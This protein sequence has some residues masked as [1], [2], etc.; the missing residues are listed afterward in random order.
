MFLCSINYTLFFKLSFF[1]P[2]PLGFGGTYNFSMDLEFGDLMLN[3]FLPFGCSS[4]PITRSYSAFLSFDSK[5]FFGFSYFTG[6]SSSLSSF[7]LF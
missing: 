2:K 7:K 4:K 3:G 1:V 6:R 5:A